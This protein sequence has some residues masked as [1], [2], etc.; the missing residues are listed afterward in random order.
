MT[1]G[2][3]A[4]GVLVESHMGRP[5]KIEGNPDHPASMG[6]T[7][8]FAQ[9]SILGL[10]DPDRAKTVRYLGNITTWTSFLGALGAELMPIKD[11]G[12]AG[13]AILTESVTSPTLGAQMKALL[14]AM[15]AA[16][17]HQYEPHGRDNVLEGSRLAFGGAFA[18]TWYAFDK[19]DVVVSLDADFLA[20]GPGSVRYARD[21]MSKRRVRRGTT[22]ANRL[23]LV[24]TMPTP[25][26]TAA[27]HRLPL[28]PSDIEKFAFAL[29]GA[30]GVGPGGTVAGEHEAWFNALV[31][32]LE[33]TRGR[34]IV[35]AGSEQPAVVH[36]L[37]H[38]INASLGN[39]GV[40][41]FHSDPIDVA[42]A[43]GRESLRQLSADMAAGK[44]RV[45]LMVGVNPVFDAPADFGFAA[46]LEKVPFR[47]SLSMY[48][49]ETAELCH[50]HVPQTHY[51]ESWGDARAFD[52]TL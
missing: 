32:D 7:D 23:Y 37:A 39:T 36:A 20:S 27:D 2:G 46:A 41:V 21:F 3:A 44:I 48:Y 11:A 5:T 29:G 26:G 40:T 9:A 16:Q 33:A 14:A 19:A 47:A 10:Y 4:T 13:L 51:L 31:K 49:D 25:T 42:P 34:S 8:I 17:W 28:K 43:I 45:L 38:A 50:W 30:F 18:S 1:R 15:P 22:S 24:E 6:A 35:V 52:G 12:G